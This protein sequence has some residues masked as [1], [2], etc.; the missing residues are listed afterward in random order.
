MNKIKQKLQDMIDQRAPEWLDRQVVRLGKD[1]TQL[2]DTGKPGVLWARLANGKPIQVHV[3]GVNV[4]SRF[5]LRLIVGRKKSQPSIWQAITILEDYDAPAGGG[6][7]TYH[8]KQHEEEGGDRLNLSWKQIVARSVRVKNTS[9]FI[10][11]VF[12]D[13]DLTPNGY[14]LIP[15]Q[16]MNLSSY[17]PAT[18]ALFLA[19]ES[20]DDGELSINAGTGFAAPGMGTAADYPVPAAGKYTRALVLLFEG[21]TSLLDQHIIIPKPPSFNPV[22]FASTIH[23]HFN[24][25]EGDPAD[26]TSGAAEDG[27]SIYAAR[28]DHVHH[29]EFP[30]LVMATGVTNPPVPVQNA[31]GT[32]W[33]YSNP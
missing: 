5:D 9:G 12:G 20:D 1:D 22:G 15:T 4:P 26:T 23:T 19:I 14:V 6:E 21:Q 3:S 28:R 29:G 16:D 13:P 30:K 32:N 25:A 10:V 27:T 33:I 7:L 2:I 24:D 17:V 11:R 31:E 18:G 8:H